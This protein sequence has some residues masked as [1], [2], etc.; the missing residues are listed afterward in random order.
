MSVLAPSI[1]ILW[2]VIESY[3]L[4]P[5]IYFAREGVEVEWPMEPGTRLPYEIV[6]RVRARAAADSDDPAFGLRAAGFV[7]PSQLGALGYAFLASPTLRDAFTCMQ[8]YIRVLNDQSRFDVDETDDRVVTSIT[9]NQ[10]SNNVVARDD[11]QIAYAVT[12]CR[13]NAGKDFDPVEVWFR[14]DEPEDRKP[15][16]DLF[17]CPVS[18]G[19]ESN[20][21]AVN[22][23]D[24]LR[25]LPSANPILAQMNE[26][27]VIQRLAKLDQEDIPNRARAAIMEQLPSGQVSDESVAEA[28]HMTSRTLHRRL[29]DAG[30][31]FRGTLQEVRRELADQYIQDRSLTLTEIT[32]LLGFSEVSSFSR[33]FKNWHGV[34]PSE[35]RAAG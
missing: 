4:D 16:E 1:G 6:D 31:T 32:F 28:L 26:R 25:T 33:A 17:R 8:R 34:P 9:V 27:V 30:L 11:S 10:D 12:L 19:A 22:R 18:F 7:H 20:A 15:Y 13:M 24:A 2:R 21:L 29:S 14:H 3:G 35:A 23:A 5:K